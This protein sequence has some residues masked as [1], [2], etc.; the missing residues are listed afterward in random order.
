VPP[1][2]RS[3]FIHLYFDVLWLGIFNG[4]TAVFLGIYVSRLGAEP[5]QVGLLTAAP[6]L[7]NL[8][9]TLPGT[10]LIRGRST[11]PVMRWA[12]LFTRLAYGLLIPLPALL[13]APAQIWVV[14][15]T[16][17]TLS[18]P[19]TIQAVVGNAWFAETV[20]MEWRGRVVG[21][22]LAIMSVMTMLTSFA[23]GQMLKALPFST[24][25][26]VVFALGFLG[27]MFSTL[28]VFLIRPTC[29][30]PPAP[31]KSKDQIRLDVW[32]GPFKKVLL[33]MVAYQVAVYLPSPMFPLYQVNQLKLT[34]QAISLATS[35]FYIVHFLGS[36]QTGILSSRLGFKR[37]SGI[38]VVI[39]GC[40][41]L[42]FMLSYR[43][44]IYML[45]QV[46]G[47][48]GWSM[49][50]GGMVNYLLERI[51]ENDRQAHLAWYNLAINAAIL[52][53]GLLSPQIINLVGLVPGMGLAVAVRLLAG[54]A[55]LRWG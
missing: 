51:P 36:T 38:G 41:T 25:Y 39:A 7:M 3:N 2:F 42:L 31:V 15:A 48:I 17:F 23:V 49:V 52:G 28:H 44:W 50:G 10:S 1:Q 19:G 21:N 33:L 40:S 46:V 5:F 53:C 4:S 16:V 24:G 9:V 26:Q 32:A 45:C 43:T 35:V 29:P 30:E 14:I 47:G 12:C 18:I 6:A 27:L 22:R 8:L 20:P 34:D 11:Y 55:I 54:L 37:L 13:E